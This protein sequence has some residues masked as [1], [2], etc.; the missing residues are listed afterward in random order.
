MAAAEA[1]RQ[2]LLSG[3]LSPHRPFISFSTCTNEMSLTT[4]NECT[5]GAVHITRC[6]SLG[7]EARGRP[8]AYRPALE[9]HRAS[10]SWP[11]YKPRRKNK[12]EGWI[13]Q[14]EYENPKWIPASL[15]DSVAVRKVLRKDAKQVDTLRGPVGETR[16]Q[17]MVRTS[18][19][20]HVNVNPPFLMSYLIPP[21]LRR[22]WGQG[23]SKGFVKKHKGSFSENESESLQQR[24]H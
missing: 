16:Q 2:P 5:R 12:H 3:S 6:L 19:A 21:F 18:A 17:L 13:I 8:F 14:P 7:F 20:N 24:T 1:R 22:L 4:G 23:E 11:W 9:I 10:L 15:I